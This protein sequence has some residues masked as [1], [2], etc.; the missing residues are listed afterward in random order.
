MRPDGR[1][2]DELRPARITPDTLKYA[3]GSALIECGNTQVLR[4]AMA[5]DSVPPFLINRGRG[6]GTA[7]Y[8]MLPAPTLTRHARN[9]RPGTWGDSAC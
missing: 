8:A 3:H 9:W 5:E 4:T 1:R 2:A 7:E 6:W